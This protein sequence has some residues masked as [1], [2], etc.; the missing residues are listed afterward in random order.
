MNKCE[1][2]VILV[3]KDQLETGFSVLIDELSVLI[4]VWQQCWNHAA[5]WIYGISINAANE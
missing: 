5:A 4:V 1:C 3:T 2:F